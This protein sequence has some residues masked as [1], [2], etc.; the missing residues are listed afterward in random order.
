MA[1]I[2]G[3][4]LRCALGDMRKHPHRRL[5]MG[6]PAAKGDTSHFW[7]EDD[8]GVHDNS[9]VAPEDYVYEGRAVGHAAVLKELE[10][11]GAIAP[12]IKVKRS[13]T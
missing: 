2:L 5:M 10:E 3:T 12:G 9:G 4:C 6:G 8:D 13:N 7:T 11:L 1:N